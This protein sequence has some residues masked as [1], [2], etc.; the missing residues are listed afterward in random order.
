MQGAENDF[1]GMVAVK[2][3]SPANRQ[4]RILSDMCD[5]ASVTHSHFIYA[6]IIIQI[7]LCIV[8]PPKA[9]EQYEI[10]AILY[11]KQ[12]TSKLGV[13]IW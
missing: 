9:G 4:G 3:S 2:K 7:W 10:T 13:I 5:M 12:Y 11:H 6:F 1:L 8:P